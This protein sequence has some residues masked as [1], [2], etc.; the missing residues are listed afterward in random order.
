MTAKIECDIVDRPGPAKLLD[1]IFK[2]EQRHICAL[3][4]SDR[5]LGGRVHEVIIFKQNRSDGA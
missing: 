1:H 2:P 4:E 5:W 3:I